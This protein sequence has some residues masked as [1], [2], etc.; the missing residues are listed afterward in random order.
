MINNSYCSNS[1]LVSGGFFLPPVIHEQ[2][3]VMDRFWRMQFRQRIPARISLMSTDSD[4]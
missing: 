2:Y 3:I 1:V 4:R